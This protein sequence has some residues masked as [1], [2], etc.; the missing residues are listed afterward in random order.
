MTKCGIFLIILG[1]IA[2]LCTPFVPESNLAI[3]ITFE[4]PT[5]TMCIMSG[6]WMIHENKLGKT[7]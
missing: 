6:I 1:I 4:G 5:A 2:I 3:Y 7:N